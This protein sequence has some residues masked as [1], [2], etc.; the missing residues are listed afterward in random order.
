[1]RSASFVLI[2]I[3]AL[4]SLGACTNGQGITIAQGPIGTFTEPT[5]EALADNQVPASVDGSAAPRIPGVVYASGN[6]LLPLAGLPLRGAQISA[7]VQAP[8]TGPLSTVAGA[9]LADSLTSSTGTTTILNGTVPGVANATVAAG[10]TAAP[11]GMSTTLSPTVTLGTPA[12]GGVA[13]GLPISPGNA[14]G[15]VTSSIGLTASVTTSAVSSANGLVSSLVLPGPG[16][17]LPI[18]H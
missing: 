4:A 10:V 16:S 7:T 5:Q 12:T 14:L 15:G 1:M 6:V 3:A 18:H 9:P 17:P 11:G 8:G 2:Q 13:P